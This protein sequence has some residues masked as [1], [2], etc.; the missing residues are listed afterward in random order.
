[1]L[2]ACLEQTSQKDVTAQSNARLLLA[3]TKPV[4]VSQDITPEQSSD[5]ESGNG[6]S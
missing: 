5:V 6:I 1:M 3:G 4:G 2:T